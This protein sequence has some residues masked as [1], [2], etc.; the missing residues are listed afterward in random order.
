M[1]IPERTG[2]PSIFEHV[3]YIIKENRTYDQLFG[4]MPEGNGDPEL[5]VFGR[6]VTP[7]HHALAEQFVL[8]DN[9]Y[10]CAEVS[11]DGW[12]WSTAGM[13]N[14]YTVRNAPYS[15]SRRG[16]EYDYEGQN[17]GVAVDLE[18][19]LDVARPPGGYIWDRVAEKGLT[20]RNY[21]F[22][23]SF[24]SGGADGRRPAE[25]NTPTKRRL[26]EH[27]DRDFLRFDMAYADSDAWVIHD[28]PAPQQRRS[29]GRH[30]AP[31]RF[32]EWKREF[33]GYVRAGR[34]PR[35]MMVRLPRDH[36]Q[37]TAAGYHSPRA[38]VADNDYAIGQLVEA[39][40]RSPFWSR[41][42]IFFLEDDAQ[43]GFDHVDAHRSL[44]LVVS[45][46]VERSTADHRFYNTDS[47]LRTMELLLGLP[48]MN[49]YD[50]IAPPLRVFGDRPENA[51]P[52]RALLPPRAIIAETNARTAYR[53]ADSARFNFRDADAVP[54]AQLNDI[55]WHALK[56]PGLPPPPIRY[57]LR[58]GPAD[59]D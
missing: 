21:G 9:F 37:G 2:E 17:N 23:V 7:N 35:F 1:P 20:Y 19:V 29:Y 25:E 30:R 16:R 50:A 48:P 34:L 53:A 59:R 32:A 56:G 4:D 15:Y 14:A 42:A 11:A 58:L 51:E 26:L 41:T 8:L 44:C 57:G 3:V 6:E 31:S 22:F 40:S 36:T 46:F 13:A 54:D 55:L 33:D 27:T 10:C 24:P 38:M 52:Y 12:N 49:Q 5:C 47:A 28:A 43:N 18:G 39:V 45:P